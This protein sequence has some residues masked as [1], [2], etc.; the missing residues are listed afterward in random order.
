MEADMGIQP[1]TKTK[2]VLEA[3]VLE[4]ELQAKHSVERRTWRWT[5][6]Q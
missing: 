6:T 4:E 1:N 5:T 2:M 3:A